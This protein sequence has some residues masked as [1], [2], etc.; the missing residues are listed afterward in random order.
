MLLIAGNL[1]LRLKS[2]VTK[3]FKQLLDL[4]FCLGEHLFE[5]NVLMGAMLSSLDDCIRAKGL[6]TGATV[7][8]HLRSQVHLAVLP[9]IRLD[10]MYQVLGKTVRGNFLFS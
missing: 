6:L 2:Q 9:L 7:E 10:D 8:E 4:V 1:L 5:L 3:L